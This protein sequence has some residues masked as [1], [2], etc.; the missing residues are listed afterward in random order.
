MTLER[1][2]LL[3]TSLYQFILDTNINHN[4]S[5]PPDAALLPCDQYHEPLLPG[6]PRITSLIYPNSRCGYNMDHV[7]S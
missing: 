1:L 4:M 2:V 3:R 5:M 7:P 6:N